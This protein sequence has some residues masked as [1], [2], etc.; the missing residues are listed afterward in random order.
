MQA[1]KRILLAVTNDLSS[2]QRVHKVC[3]TLLSMGFDTTL[4]G[5]RKRSNMQ[6]EPRRYKTKR[7]FLF[8]EKGPLFYAEYNLR[9][10]LFLL[11]NKADVIV[12]NDLDTLPACYLASIIKGSGLVHDSHEYFTGVPE[13]QGRAFARWVWKRFE[14]WIFPKLK[15]VYTVNASIANLYHE[16]YGNEVRVVRNFPLKG[17]GDQLNVPANTKVPV[18]EQAVILYQGSVNVDRGL[19]EAVE[20]MQYVQGAILLIVGD[21]DILGEVKQKVKDLGL[22]SKVHFKK[23]VPFNELKQFT[24]IASLGISLDR[25]TNLNYRFSLPNKIFDFVQAGVPVL[26]SS[27]VEIKKIFEKY[28]IGMM[29][30][31]HDPKEIAACMQKMISD[32]EMQR[33]W[34]DNCAKAAVEYCWENEEPVL[35]SVYSS[36]V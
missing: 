28:E 6:I 20:A 18:F 19:I 13:L 4:V 9:L 2:E 23:R 36:F 22:E 31:S 14:S 12:S 33:M 1:K 8:F 7:M 35:K 21:G 5:R 25:D 24:S 26:A 16:K 30:S 11:F 27:M 34:K 29:V 17:S 15:Y 10:F 3:L 32:K